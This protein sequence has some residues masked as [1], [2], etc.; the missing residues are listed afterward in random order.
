MKL[1]KEL[2]YVVKEFK[3]IKNK[4]PPYA[5]ELKKEGNYKDFKTRLAWDCLYAVIPINT[6][7]NWYDEYNCN[8]NHVTTLAK[9]ALKQ[10]YDININ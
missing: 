9:K 8:D 10:V 4:I 6:V 1:N 7:C 3:K 5:E 2:P